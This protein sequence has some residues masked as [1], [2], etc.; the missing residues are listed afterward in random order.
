MNVC[1]ILDLTPVVALTSWGT[2]H[3]PEEKRI[4]EFVVDIRGGMWNSLR[5][6]PCIPAPEG[7]FP[8]IRSGQEKYLEVFEDLNDDFKAQMI[9]KEGLS[10]EEVGR[11]VL[12][13]L[14]RVD[15]PYSLTKELASLK[16]R[17]EVCGSPASEVKSRKRFE[18][19]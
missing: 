14:H 17:L 12:G 2:I 10:A 15:F 5:Y 1:K 18:V 16:K 11:L 13:E 6:G 3:F 4:I 9:C 7:G 8:E 19:E